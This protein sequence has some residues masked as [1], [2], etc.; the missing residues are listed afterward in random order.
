MTVGVFEMGTV[1]LSSRR[2]T[3]WVAAALATAVATIFAVMAAQPEVGHA[4][5]TCTKPQ[6]LGVVFVVDDSGSMTSN[7]P[8]K[9]AGSAVGIAL[10]QLPDGS[11]TA[12]TQF[13]SDAT[14]LI[15]PTEVNAASRGAIKTEI[16]A[17]LKQSGG[18]DF[19]D[20]FTNAKT[21]LDGLGAADRKAIVFLTDGQATQPADAQLQGLGAPVYV[22][23]F[24]QYTE[25]TLKAI[26]DK[27][28][29][30]FTPATSAGDLQGI[31]GR[32]VASLTCDQ[33]S[34]STTVVLQKGESKDVPFD[35]S[36]GDGSFRALATW[37]TGKVDVKAI[38]PDASE[39]TP[40]TVKPTELF[41]LQPT[42]ALIEGTLPPPGKWNVRLT[43]DPANL[44]AVNVSIDVWRR[45]LAIR[46]ASGIQVFCNRA[47]QK[48]VAA[49]CTATV[50]D[51]EKTK[52]DKQT[53]TGTVTFSATRGMPASAS[54]QLVPTPLSPGVASC[55]VMYTPSDKDGIGTAF[56]VTMVYEGDGVFNGTT[57]VHKLINAACVETAFSKCTD[58]VSVDLLGNGVLD[59]SNV[60]LTVKCGNT[61]S[62]NPGDACGVAVGMTADLKD[63]ATPKLTPPTA[64]ATANKKKK[65]KA[66]KKNRQIVKMQTLTLA[67]GKKQTVKLKL[68]KYGKAYKKSAKKAKGKKYRTIPVV[69][70]V[71]V[72]VANASKPI[73]VKKKIKLRIK[74]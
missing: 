66:K 40:A 42:Y 18:T 45:A 10:D 4:Q 7:D 59:G 21:L 6:K 67:A 12:V 38:R 49:P 5:N 26:A 1:G 17:K 29:G 44:A 32:T 43:A 25:S 28:G 64:S 34:L 35:V 48:G 37:G 23:G 24:G 55:K 56:P 11:L 68:N 58:G 51:A 36:N 74:K 2:L 22:V 27:T 69:V 39:L 70:H 3:W 50:A 14:T 65:T 53:P 57:G 73:V 71:S 60:S 52:P 31:F 63:A 61:A 62:T 8:D 16:A 47:A 19:V 41:T 72:K 15:P 33:Q 54:C 30:T 9:L 20:A 13:S 46:R